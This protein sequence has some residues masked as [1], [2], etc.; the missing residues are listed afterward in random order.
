MV[1]YKKI[2]KKHI[3]LIDSVFQNLHNRAVDVFRTTTKRTFL[4][5]SAPFI[6]ENI[7]PFIRELQNNNS[8]EGFSFIGLPLHEGGTFLEIEGYF[9]ESH[10]D[11]VVLMEDPTGYFQFAGGLGYDR[12]NQIFLHSYADIEVLSVQVSD[13]LVVPELSNVIDFILTIEMAEGLLQEHLDFLK[14]QDD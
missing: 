12:S 2:T 1:T 9:P 13:D 11:F 5:H 14:P 3:D 10:D 8:L 7:Y 4:F 6:D